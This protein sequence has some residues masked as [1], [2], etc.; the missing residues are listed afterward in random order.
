MTINNFGRNS[1]VTWTAEDL[2]KE[3]EAEI[4]MREIKFRAWDEFNKKMV[5]DYDIWQPNKTKLPHLPPQ[6]IRLCSHFIIYPFE[7]QLKSYVRVYDE[8]NRG[9]DYYKG[10]DY[11]KRFSEGLIFMQ[12]TGLKDKNGKDLNWWEGDIFARASDG[13]VEGVIIYDLGCFWL[14]RVRGGRN[15]LYE[16]IDWNMCRINNIHQNPELME[17]ENGK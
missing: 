15:L 7:T 5:Y 14:D 17:Q 9:T 13:K 11:D 4:Q 12:F 8:Q 1:L 3:R 10:W 6:Q 16:C 2:R